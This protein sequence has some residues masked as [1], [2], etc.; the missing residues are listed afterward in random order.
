MKVEA[1]GGNHSPWV[2][3]VLLGPHDR[4]VE[5]GLWPLPPFETLK[6]WGVFMR[7]LSIDSG[8]W[9]IE[10]SQILVKLGFEPISDK[11]LQAIKAAWQG[12]LHRA[13]KPLNFFA[14]FARA[15]DNYSWNS[16]G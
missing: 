7:A 15:E 11:D 12:V 16:T 3:A 1:Y 5:H 14:A 6:R 8:P 9:E 13:D 10:S 4:G 2:Q